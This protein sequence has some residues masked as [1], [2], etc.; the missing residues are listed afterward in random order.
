ML[1]LPLSQQ[2]LATPLRA[3]DRRVG[4]HQDIASSGEA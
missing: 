3:P 2:S 1:K 4:R